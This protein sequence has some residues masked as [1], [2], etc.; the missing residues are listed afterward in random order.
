MISSQWF[1][2]CIDLYFGATF[3][4]PSS[5]STSVSLVSSQTSSTGSPSRI[6]YAAAGKA[7]AELRPLKLKLKPA[8]TAQNWSEQ[9]FLNKKFWYL[10]KIKRT[11]PS[12]NMVSVVNAPLQLHLIQH[13]EKGQGG[14]SPSLATMVRW[15]T[16]SCS[17]VLGILQNSNF[18]LS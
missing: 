4:L 6:C 18:V 13:Q 3:W 7:S 8:L 10:P 14:H 1:S 11:E 5:D 16:F 17:I 15:G 2:L 12:V 9:E